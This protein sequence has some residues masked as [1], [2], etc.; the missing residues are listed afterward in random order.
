MEG[1]WRHSN[2]D[3]GAAMIIPVPVPLGGAVVVGEASITYL[4]GAQPAKSVPLKAT[5]VRVRRLPPGHTSWCMEECM[6]FVVYC[7]IKAFPKTG[8]AHA[9]CL[10]D[11]V[12]RMTRGCSDLL[13]FVAVPGTG[14]GA[15]VG[16]A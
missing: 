13:L 5:I 9:S 14:K 11:A 12:L 2:L 15:Q 7:C 1:P 16:R 10:A 3:A 4:S 8:K 6:L